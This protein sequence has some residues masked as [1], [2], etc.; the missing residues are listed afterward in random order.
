M[1]I[2]IKLGFNQAKVIPVLS[3]DNRE[4]R[5]RVVPTGTPATAS[6]GDVAAGFHTF[7]LRYAEPQSVA[8]ILKRLLPY[9]DNKVQVENESHAIVVRDVDPELL[10]EIQAFIAE[11]DKP[12]PQVFLDAQ[13]VEI[14]AD[15]VSKLGISTGST[16]P[17]T[18]S[19]KT[20]TYGSVQ[21]PLQPIVR[22]PLS[23]TMTLDALKG[24]GK[25]RVLANPRVTTM[26]GVEAAVITGER[27]PIFVTET[28]GNQTF[29][30]KQDIVAGIELRITPRVNEGDMITTKIRTQVSS[31]T[32]VTSA[33]YPTTSTREATTT[34]RVR[35]G[36]TIVIGG[37]KETRE[38]KQATRIPILGQIPWIGRLFSSERV[39]TRES[40]LF[41]FVTPYLIK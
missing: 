2:P 37:L 3:G 15:D 9:G 19:E 6:E 32:G 29:T 12:L 38:I 26:D 27:F 36:E 11:V 25:A 4:L 17:V 21:M 5:I 18:F 7:F 10:A 22:T 41:I 33:G 24:D 31:I 20:E 34:I 40:E 14:N 16:L 30:I 23:L 28:N 1:H 35:A 39:E 13:I 8:D